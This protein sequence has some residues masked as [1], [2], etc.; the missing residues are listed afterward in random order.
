[1]LISQELLPSEWLLGSVC[2]VV[3]VCDLGRLS[4]A[5]GK[6][7]PNTSVPKCLRVPL[8][9]IP[10][11]LARGGPLSLQAIAG[12]EASCDVAWLLKKHSGSVTRQ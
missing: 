12:E 5:V 2:E 9:P 4:G 6:G 1:M 11:D 3:R 8:L 10:L 7:F